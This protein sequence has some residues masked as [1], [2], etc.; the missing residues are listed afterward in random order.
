MTDL[1]FPIGKF[2]P[3]AANTAEVRA[4]H[5]ANIRQLPAQL[6]QAI[7]DLSDVQLDTPYRDGGWTVRQTV[8]HLADSHMMSF[9]RFKLALTADWPTISAYDEVAWANL[10]DSRLPLESSFQILEGLHTRWVALLESMSEEDFNK[11]INHPERGRMNLAAALAIY[12]WHSLHH[13]AH[14]TRLRERMGW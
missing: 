4:Q 5:I 8:H 14:I 12:S 10:P 9:S 13:T 6:R 2:A 1:R 7:S 11:G 3:P